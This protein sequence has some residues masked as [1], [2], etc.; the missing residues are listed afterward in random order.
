MT[1][2]GCHF[3]VVK[4]DTPG[5]NEDVDV[6]CAPNAALPQNSPLAASSPLVPAQR[7]CRDDL[8]ERWRLP[9]LVQMH[10]NGLGRALVVPVLMSMMSIRARKRVMCATAA[11]MLVVAEVGAGLGPFAFWGSWRNLGQTHETS[12]VGGI[13][14]RARLCIY[15]KASP[16][17]SRLKSCPGRRMRVVPSGEN[18]WMAKIALVVLIEIVT[19]AKP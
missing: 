14:R 5:L 7:R 4:S 18:R 12:H 11:L 9:V 10:Q 8:Q 2:V 6:T 16:A 1:V 15:L 3:G 19:V 13:G 17:G